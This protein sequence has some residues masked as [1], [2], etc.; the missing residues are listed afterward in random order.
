MKTKRVNL[1]DSE[2]EQNTANTYLKAIF[3][4]E[5]R[6]ITSQ[7][8]F[9]E[10][11]SLEENDTHN[12]N[13]P[14]QTLIISTDKDNAWQFF[15][16]LSMGVKEAASYLASSFLEGFGS[17]KND[18][19]ACVA[20]KIGVLLQDPESIAIVGDDD[21]PLDAI[22]LAKKCVAQID[23]NAKEVGSKHITYE[24]A[25]GYGLTIDAILESNS[26][27]TFSANIIDGSIKPYAE[28]VELAGNNTADSSCCMVM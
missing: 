11:R 7:K 23:K 27:P 16:C 6:F 26:Q 18:F 22:N 9:D 8:V 28:Y 4:K 1:P 17:V 20:M 21:I 12:T 19:L 24:E 3:N 15:L 25:I 13:A 10:N 14:L 2:R 5:G